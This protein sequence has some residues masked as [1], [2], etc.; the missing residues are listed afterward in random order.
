M[1]QE[2]EVIK[3][4]GGFIAAVLAFFG[5]KAMVVKEIEAKLK[6]R[7][8]LLHAEAKLIEE[9]NKQAKITIDRIEAEYK[10]KLGKDE[11][12]LLCRSMKQEI[13]SL[14]DCI[15]LEF[16]AINEKMDKRRVDFD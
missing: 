16:R 3:I 13:S 4:G 2:G 8:D 1:I 12:V 6:L 7:I 14:R 11:H 5:L 10:S 15:K 9:K